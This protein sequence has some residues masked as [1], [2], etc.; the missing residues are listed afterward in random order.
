MRGDSLMKYL[1]RQEADR[2]RI[3]TLKRGA[4]QVVI[5]QDR[6]YPTD[7]ELFYRDPKNSAA[8]AMFDI[9]NIQP[10]RHEPIYYNT[11]NL[12][13]LNLSSK[14]AGN[15]GKKILRLDPNKLQQYLGT[16][17]IGGALLWWLVGN[18]L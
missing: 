7:D 3:Y 9:D 6:L 10:Y 16:I 17:A 4:R 5:I 15:R 8:Y 13:I 2:F 14:T 11:R 1:I 18:V 12:A